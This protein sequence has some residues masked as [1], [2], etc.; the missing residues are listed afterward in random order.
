MNSVEC[1][2]A[3]ATE[4]TTET[5][6]LPTGDVIQVDVPVGQEPPTVEEFLAGKTGKVPSTGGGV[7]LL[8]VGAVGVIGVAMFVGQGGIK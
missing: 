6:V 2:Y 3:P 7:P 4:V 8:L 1:G 5:L